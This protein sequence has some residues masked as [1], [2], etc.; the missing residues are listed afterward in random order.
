[1][2][3]FETDETRMAHPSVR[4]IPDDIMRDV[5]NYE[6]SDFK[7][8]LMGASWDELMLSL[9][10]Y[11]E[12]V[13]KFLD[14][15]CIAFSHPLW[16]DDE[17]VNLADRLSLSNSELL[18]AAILTEE[19]QVINSL[20]ELSPADQMI[21][22][23]AEYYRPFRK[24][25]ERCNLRIMERL[26][27]ILMELSP[28]DVFDMLTV[29]NYEIFRIIASA[30][31]LDI[32]GRLVHTLR[33]I[34]PDE[35]LRMIRAEGYLMVRTALSQRCSPVINRLVELDPSLTSGHGDIAREIANLKREEL[36]ESI[37][38]AAA[39]DCFFPRMRGHREEVTP[40]YVPFGLG[41]SV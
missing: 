15:V 28:D 31:R 22:L 13:N 35:V 34:S 11:P 30:G 17:L 29:N 25:A 10:R 27:E 40:Q 33:E 7:L 12:K 3:F 8:E 6:L 23:R 32:L 20:M 14:W 9:E 2:P 26:I 41:V 39:P 4:F 37:T 24:A 19:L 16:G 21:M 36:S 5:F 38:F 18:E 1:M